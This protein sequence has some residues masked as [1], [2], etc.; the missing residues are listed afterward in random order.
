MYLSKIVY[1]VY[2]THTLTELWVPAIYTITA[3]FRFDIDC[4]YK[5]TIE[6]LKNNYSFKLSTFTAGISS[7]KSLS[8]PE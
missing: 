2:E 5:P 3:R 1:Y 4:M 6:K 8:S 7:T